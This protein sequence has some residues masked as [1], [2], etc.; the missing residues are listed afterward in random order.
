MTTKSI[1]NRSKKQKTNFVTWLMISISALGTLWGAHLIANTEVA[2]EQEA[3]LIRAENNRVA[4]QPIARS[5]S[6]R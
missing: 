5:R 2:Q 3:Q 4:N 6:S 1:A